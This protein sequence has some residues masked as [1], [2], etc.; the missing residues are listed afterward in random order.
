MNC[1]KT[2]PMCRVA[3]VTSIA[4]FILT[5]APLA[6][7]QM[8][9]WA[10]YSENAIRRAQTDGSGIELLVSGTDAAEPTD[11]T[12]DLRAGKIYWCGL[13][14]ASVRR[15]NLDGTNVEILTTTGVDFPNGIALDVANDQMYVTNFNNDQI[16]RYDLDGSGYLAIH[17]FPADSW[18][19][20]IDLD[21][22]AGKM[23]Y[24]LQGLG[25]IER[26][27]LDGSGIEVLVDPTGSVPHDLALDIP[28]G[29]IYWV[30]LGDDEIQRCN[31]DGSNVETVVATGDR[32]R[33]L[34]LDL[35]QGKLWWTK[36][37]GTPP[38]EIRRSN[39]DGT[40]IETILSG[41]PLNDP[42]GITVD[43]RVVVYDNGYTDPTSDTG[44]EMSSWVQADDFELAGPTNLSGVV[45]DWF[46]II[47]GSW[48]GQAQWY[49][50]SD[51]AGAPGTLLH[52]G[53]GINRSTISLG[54]DQ[55]RY[56]YQTDVMFDSEFTLATATR[57]W[58]GLHWGAPGDF[59][60]DDV[61]W[62]STATGGF[63]TTG[64]ESQGGTFDNWSS[65]SHHRAFRLLG[66]EPCGLFCDGFESGD[67]TEWTTA[68]G[69]NPSP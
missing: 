60:D 4:M 18:P 20:G 47:E 11:L 31:L 36:P 59:D 61:Y 66:G 62:A 38:S 33:G 5:S 39:L 14:P 63:G 32:P 37:E 48:D 56:W 8:V 30:N 57:Y 34:A 53:N 40:G 10:D 54:T 42:W 64:Q 28:G 1:L 19:R 49:V 69:M 52:Q 25:R 16:N 23:Y 58:V 65:N 13:G 2:F 27:N 9:Y 15:A 55:G 67:T 43:S 46:E 41:T 7:A 17:T 51:N 45:I 29:K 6:D 24:Q 12:L 68:T 22:D 35:S 50:F 21:L 44:N 3:L 26:S